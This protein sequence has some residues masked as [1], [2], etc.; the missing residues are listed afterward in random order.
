M[1]LKNKKIALVHDWL[2]DLGGAE[3]TLKVLHEMFPDA[4]IYTFFYDKDFTDKFLP[5]AISKTT[6]IQRLRK[7][8]KKHRLFLPL[9]PIAAES[10]DLSDYDIVISSS[11]SFSKGLIVN[12]NTA[13]ICYCYSPTRFLW[14]WSNEYTRG[15]GFKKIPLKIIQHFLRIWDSQSSNRVDEFIA[16]SK[17]VQNRIKKYYRRDSE[18]IYPPVEYLETENNISENF[19][20]IVSR[21]FPHK[22]INIAIEAFNKLGYPLVIIGG[23]PEYDRLNK[24]SN[25]NITFLGNLDDKEVA[26]YYSRCRAFILPQEEDFGLTPIE[27]MNYGK[28][29]LALKKGGAIEYILENINGE[30][31]NDPT[32]EVLAD[33][34]R[35]LNENYDKYSPLVIK[36]TAEKFSRQRF[37]NEIL[38]FLSKI[39]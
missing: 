8:T 6:F 18:V 34:V 19:Y 7:W 16:I 28:P 4:P 35:R 26:S 20:L 12:L 38:K 31:F 29:V 17:N 5:N 2:L 11:I 15:Q 27:A 10:I 32:P 30:F 22:N 37:E 21:L 3:K 13:H 36:K 23:G 25:K 24:I 33:G 1:I 14:D 39:I 9:I